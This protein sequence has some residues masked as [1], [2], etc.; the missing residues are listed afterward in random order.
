MA[1]YFIN[2]F[3]PGGRRE[4]G[5]ATLTSRAI[6]ESDSSNRFIRSVDRS[7]DR[8]MEELA[9]KMEAKAKRYAPNR[10]GRLRNSIQAVMLSNGR[11]V[12]LFSDV[13]YAGHMEHGTR[14]HQ[15]SGVKANFQWRGGYF[16]WNDPDF[17]PIGK[18]RRTPTKYANWTKAGGATVNHPGTRPH[19]FF[20][21]AFTETWQEARFIM[22]RVYG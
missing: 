21:R 12:R 7:G 22:R 11:E 9:N 1:S 17:G 5:R 20:A 6:M 18:K 15:I 13:D 19:R 16:V 3:G 4:V 10:T 14:P 2:G 8:L